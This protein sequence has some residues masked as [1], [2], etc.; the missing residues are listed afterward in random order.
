MFVT[1]WI[2]TRINAILLFQ[3]N[4]N[5]NAINSSCHN[6]LHV[7][8]IFVLLCC[9]VWRRRFISPSNAIKYIPPAGAGSSAAAAAT[10]PKQPKPTSVQLEQPCCQIVCC[11]RNSFVFVCF[12]MNQHVALKKNRVIYAILVIR[13]AWGAFT[14]K[15]SRNNVSVW[16]EVF[17][18][19]TIWG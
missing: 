6:I 7:M 8:G 17:V 9:L 5:N 2:W 16:Q 19:E 4:H 14:K 18:V 11:Q 15:K 12:R 1:N 10:P 13:N 3:M